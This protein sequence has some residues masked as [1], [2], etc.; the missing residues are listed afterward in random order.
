MSSNPLEDDPEREHRIRHRAY[1]LWEHEGRPHGQDAEFWERAR[2]LVGIEESAGS[3]QLPNPVTTGQDPLR[4]QPVEEAFLQ[5]NLGEFPGRFTDQGETEPTPKSRRAGAA[6][7]AP[8]RMPAPR[9]ATPPQDA[10]ETLPAKPSLKAK[11]I[12]QAEKPAPAAR[13]KPPAA[14]SSPPPTRKK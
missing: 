2:E 9:P 10:P 12:K 4:E 8:V 14:S 1:H 6:A 3:G 7:A 11:A 5:E 13:K